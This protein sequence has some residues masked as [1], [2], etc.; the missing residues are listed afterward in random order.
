MKLKELLQNKEIVF[1]E[2][3]TIEKEKN[4]Y[5]NIFI[6]LLDSKNP[7][8]NYY[9]KFN[10]N[11]NDTQVQFKY[12]SYP[13]FCQIK[14]Y[15]TIKD[16]YNL[17]LKRIQKQN[18]LLK[19]SNKKPIIDLNIIHGEE[20]KNGSFF[21][22]INFF[23]FKG[24]TC[25]F[26]GD[27]NT[28]KYYCSILKPE[29]FN[30]T[31]EEYFDKIKEPIILLATSE[32]YNLSNEKGIYENCPLNSNNNLTN[33]LTQEEIT[34]KNCLDLFI[35]NENIQEDDSWFCSKCKKLQKSKL[36]LQ[37]YKPPHYLIFLLKRYDFKKN[38]GNTFYGEKNNNFVLYPIKD[39]DIREYIVGPEKNKAIYDLYGVIEHYG[40]MN[41]GHYTAICKNN[42]KW[43]NY[44]D[45]SL[46]IAKNPI[47]KNA[48]VLFYKMHNDGEGK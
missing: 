2:K 37:I 3:K 48:Y 15:A 39:F 27:S 36:K 23:F 5:L 19:N 46:E 28:N 7:N 12:I 32:Y 11:G 20:T 1:F 17:V 29:T 9:I 24:D 35:S 10:E 43:I 45:S 4:N 31:L 16:L 6:Y 44:N 38:Y 41:Q 42:N 34:L 13:L 26:C 33:K 18:F 25:K 21:N 47:S 14:K 40:S 8:T 30:I 22:F